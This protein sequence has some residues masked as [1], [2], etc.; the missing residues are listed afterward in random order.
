MIWPTNWL[1]WQNRDMC[2][3]NTDVHGHNDKMDNRR[4]AV[5]K[6]AVMFAI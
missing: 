5:Y 1:C 3:R 6:E 2:S 4:E